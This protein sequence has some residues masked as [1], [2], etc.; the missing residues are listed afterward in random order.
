LT[1]YGI[2]FLLAIVTIFRA[3]ER[4]QPLSVWI[5]KTLVVGGLALDQL[6]QLPTLA[7]SAQ[8]QQQ[9]KKKKTSTNRRTN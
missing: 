7:E 4:G 5:P 6:T 8:Q 3:Q 2:N 1:I 9:K